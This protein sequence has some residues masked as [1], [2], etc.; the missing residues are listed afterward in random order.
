LLSIEF[1]NRLPRIVI[2]AC[3]DFAEQNHHLA[4]IHHNQ[5]PKTWIPACHAVAPARRR[6]IVGGLAK[7]G[8]N[9]AGMTYFGFC[10]L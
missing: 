5:H 4:G 10:S 2:P 7:A 6:F 3:H 9:L 8:S 1:I